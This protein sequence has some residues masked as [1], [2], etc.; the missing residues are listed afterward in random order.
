MNIIIRPN[1]YTVNKQDSVL[2]FVYTPGVDL[3]LGLVMTINF[4]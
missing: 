4:E 1:N 2:E 3:P